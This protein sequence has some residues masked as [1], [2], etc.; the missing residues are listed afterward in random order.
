MKINVGDKFIRDLDLITILDAKERTPWSTP[1]NIDMY[2]IHIFYHQT[3]STATYDTLYTVKEFKKDIKAG[4]II[5]V[6]KLHRIF[7]G[8]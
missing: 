3:K 5:P 1:W 2:H 7:Y 8:Y 6:T 4:K